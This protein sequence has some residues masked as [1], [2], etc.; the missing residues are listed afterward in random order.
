VAARS[1]IVEQHKKFRDLNA[2][3]RPLEVWPRTLGCRGM[4]SARGL[5]QTGVV[6]D[7]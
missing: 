7:Q 4:G 5:L 3:P 1:E 6:G 2:T